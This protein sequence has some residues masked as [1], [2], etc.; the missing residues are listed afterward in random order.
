[1]RFEGYKVVIREC[2]A[3]PAVARC[4]ECGD[5]VSES[6]FLVNAQSFDPREHASSCK[7]RP[8]EYGLEMKQKKKGVEESSEVE[9]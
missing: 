2:V 1:V 9:K 7:S 5:L 8:Q 3:S 6:N 4:E